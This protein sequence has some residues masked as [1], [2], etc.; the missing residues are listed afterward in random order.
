ML[1]QNRTY[2]CMHRKKALVMNTGYQFCFCGANRSPRTGLFAVCGLGTHPPPISAQNGSTVVLT[3]FN[4]P[5]FPFKQG[6][7][8][9]E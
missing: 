5:L 2:S 8:L 7:G 3:V 9:Y 1:L 6:G 4:H